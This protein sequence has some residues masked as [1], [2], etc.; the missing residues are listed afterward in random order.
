MQNSV[1][2]ITWILWIFTWFSKIYLSY[3]DMQQWD[4][5]ISYTNGALEVNYNVIPLYTVNK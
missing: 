3:E 1:H 4:I 5:L 2:N